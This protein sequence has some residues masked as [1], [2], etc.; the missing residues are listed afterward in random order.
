MLE[1]EELPTRNAERSP[2]LAI[3]DA[4]GLTHDCDRYAVYA[5]HNSF[6]GI[7]VGAVQLPPRDLEVETCA[8]GGP[9]VC[10]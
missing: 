6:S 10:G 8:N 3:V 5:C 1:A 2:C 7:A 4:D 9:R